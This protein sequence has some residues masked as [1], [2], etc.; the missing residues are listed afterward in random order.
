ML[1][2]IC[3][4]LM[5]TFFLHFFLVGIEENRRNQSLISLVLWPA[6]GAPYTLVNLIGQKQY[7]RCAK[8]IYF[9]LQASFFCLI[10]SVKSPCYFF[11]TLFSHYFFLTM[12]LLHYQS[13]TCLKQLAYSILE[14]LLVS[15]FPELKDVILDIHKKAFH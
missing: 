9:F 4:V 12:Y 6:G 15:I 8:D 14:L 1:G 3:F 11:F 13:T 5:F 10:I 7:Q 2:A